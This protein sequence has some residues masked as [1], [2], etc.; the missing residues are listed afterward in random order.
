MSDSNRLVELIEEGIHSH[1]GDL[2]GWTRHAEDA[3]Q[4]FDGRATLRAALQPS[5]R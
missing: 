4:L 1:G 3:L 2:G 5:L